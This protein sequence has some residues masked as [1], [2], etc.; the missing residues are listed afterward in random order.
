M[1]ATP[2]YASTGAASAGAAG[3]MIQIMPLLLIFV[4]FYVLML[5][6]QQQRAKQH[7]ALLDAVKKNDIAVTGGGIIGKVTK[8][9]ADEVEIE[10]AT[11]VRIKVVKAMLT[12]VR[13]NNVKP[14]N[15]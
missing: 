2:A 9:D 7:R 13:S 11:G 3:F 15:D 4:I 14:A 5:R 6:P 12:D 8:V 1:F 10:I